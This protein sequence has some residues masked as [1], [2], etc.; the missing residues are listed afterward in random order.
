MGQTTTREVMIDVA[1]RLI[2]ERGLGAVSL[3]EVQTASGQRNKSAA[4]YHFGSRDGLIEAIVEAR[5]APINQRRLGLLAD[6]D[7]AGRGN[8][9]RALVEALIEPLAEATTGRADSAYARFL[10]QA[11]T[12][13]SAAKIVGRHLR[14]ESFRAVRDRLAAAIAASDIPAPLQMARVDRANR[15]GIISLAA[16]ESGRFGDDL[17]LEARLADLIDACV[18][19]IEAPVSARTR[20]ALTQLDRSDG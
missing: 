1:E 6:L 17:P 20:T 16:W 14:A 5:M 4:H 12:D 9:V 18:A 13:P 15:L 3:R 2:A 19:L 10:A 7:V 8:D 11:L